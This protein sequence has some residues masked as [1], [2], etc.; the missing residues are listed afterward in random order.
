MAIN[1]RINK[2]RRDKKDEFYTMIED[3]EREMSHHIHHFKDKV[4]YCNYDNP[5]MSAFWKYFHVN[6]TKLG[7]KKLVAT[8]FVKDGTS[9]VCTYIGG[10]MTTLN[11][12]TPKC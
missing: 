11:N 5:K 2:A 4:V 10:M 6:F 9:Y 1:S 3:V 8:Y 12:M 7:L